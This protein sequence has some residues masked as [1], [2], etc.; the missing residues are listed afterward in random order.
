MTS[1]SHGV[2]STPTKTN[3]EQTSERIPNTALAT[4]SASFSLPW[5]RSFE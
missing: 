2:V 4:C 5:A 3:S 1:I